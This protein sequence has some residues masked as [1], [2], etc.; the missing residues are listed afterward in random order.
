VFQAVENQLLCVQQAPPLATGA[1]LVVAVS[2][3][4]EHEEPALEGQ[5]CARRMGK[6]GKKFLPLA[7]P[8]Y[9]GRRY[10]HTQFLLNVWRAR[11]ATYE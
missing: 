5:P 1:S 10:C 6:K 2:L 9:D 4:P 3:E 8:R 7:V 11:A